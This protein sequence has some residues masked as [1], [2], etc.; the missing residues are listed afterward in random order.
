MLSAAR[1]TWATSQF[2]WAPGLPCLTCI[3]SRTFCVP[4]LAMSTIFCL[5]AACPNLGLSPWSSSVFC[6]LYSASVLPTAR[7]F[8]CKCRK[9]KSLAVKR[10]ALSQ[11]RYR[12]YCAFGWG[13][14]RPRVCD[15]LSDS[16]YCYL[17]PP[18]FPVHLIWLQHSRYREGEEWR[19][20]VV[21][22]GLQPSIR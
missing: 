21:V 8:T 12:L 13:R 19:Q 14:P 15:D 17:H 16:E 3:L 20:P 1:V 4:T 6:H 18:T 9:E 10:Y 7:V 5:P 22:E 11:W 2:L